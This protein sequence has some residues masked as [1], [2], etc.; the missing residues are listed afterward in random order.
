MLVARGAVKE[1]AHDLPSV[2][3]SGIALC[4][5]AEVGVV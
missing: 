3:R 5:V 1:T 4:N 2:V